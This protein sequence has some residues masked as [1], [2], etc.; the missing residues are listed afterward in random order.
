[1]QEIRSR[2]ISIHTQGLEN[3][4]ETRH[5]LQTLSRKLDHMIEVMAP[6]PSAMTRA[7]PQH[8][9]TP[10]STNGAMPVKNGKGRNGLSL[11][12]TAAN[13]KEICFTIILLI[14][15]VGIMIGHYE[16]KDFKGLISF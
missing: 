15:T 4:M 3:Q 1:M 13:I 10:T 9:T 12:L 7:Q 6:P 16:I 8:G 2:L 14:I 5:E 11:T